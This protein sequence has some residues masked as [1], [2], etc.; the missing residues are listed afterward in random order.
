[1]RLEEIEQRLRRPH[2]LEQLYGRY[3]N[4]PQRIGRPA[5]GGGL[6]MSLL[7]IVVV[8][9]AVAVLVQWNRPV[10]AGPQPTNATAGQDP[11]PSK[12]VV[13]FPPESAAPPATGTP[14]GPGSIKGSLVG[15]GGAMGTQYALIRLEPLAA[16]CSLPLTPG[17]ALSDSA[18]STLGAS[19]PSNQDGG[20]IDLGPVLE[21]RV[22][23]ASLCGLKPQVSVVVSLD[24]G[25]GN[26]VRVPMPAQFRPGCS[27]TTVVSVDDLFVTS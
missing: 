4:R 7:P 23:V 6:G 3:R 15:L 8:A 2:P 18:G 24:F 22:G 27:G 10:G 17:V 9:V 21:A 25:N 1:M 19:A 5:F 20:R 26:V 14:C 16:A 13:S 12:S 11:E